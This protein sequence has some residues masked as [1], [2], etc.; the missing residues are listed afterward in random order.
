LLEATAMIGNLIRKLRGRNTARPKLLQPIVEH[1]EDRALP[2]ALAWGSA[3]WKTQ[4]LTVDPWRAD[5]HFGAVLVDGVLCI[6]LWADRPWSG[7][8]RFDQPRHHLYLHL[9]ID[10][11]RL[12]QSLEW[13]TVEPAALYRVEGLPTGEASSSTRACR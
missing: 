3:L 5:V 2:A 10:Y 8:L 7:R 12:N 11:S 6:S 1:L 4:G 13:F 9:P